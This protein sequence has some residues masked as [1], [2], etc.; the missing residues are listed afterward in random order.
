VSHSLIWRSAIALAV[1]ATCALL[2]AGAGASPPNLTGSWQDMSARAPRST[3]HLHATNDSQTLTG[4][5]Q[6]TLTHSGL[7]GSFHAVLDGSGSSYSGSFHVTEASVVVDG[8]I[9]IT[10]VS[11]DKISLA[12]HPNNG[13]NSSSF[14]LERH[15]VSAIRFSFRG[16]ANDVRVVPPLVGPW[17][18]GFARFSGSGTLAGSSISST[19]YDSFEPHSSRYAPAHMH[20]EVLG[21]SYRR[22]PHG[23]YSIL[24]MT[25]QI[26]ETNAK[27][28][29]PGDRG[30]LKLLDTTAKLKNGKRG[31]AIALHW[32]NGRCPTFEQGWIN[33]DGGAETSPSFGGPPDGG[34]YAIVRISS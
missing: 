12:L 14:S 15:G 31:D 4:T 9:A 26:T 22:G 32:L 20:A 29:A 21:Y 13:S 11:P 2:S 17:Q 28:C 3:W 24:E 16:Y 19:M 27:N 7:H 25:I 34:Q 1:A 8:T 6:G 23:A 30:T 5:W 33:A 10:I 18:L